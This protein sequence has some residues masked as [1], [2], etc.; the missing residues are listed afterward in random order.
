MGACCDP[1]VIHCYRWGYGSE[2]QHGGHSGRFCW[3][4]LPEGSPCRCASFSP[5][6]GLRALG[7]RSNPAGQAGRRRQRCAG[8][9]G[10]RG[11]QHGVREGGRAARCA[12]LPA[13][14]GGGGAAGRLWQFLEPLLLPA[15]A[16]RG[17]RGP[18][19]PPGTASR[20]EAAAPVARRPPRRIH[21]CSLRCRCTAGLPCCGYFP[22]VLHRLKRGRG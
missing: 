6:R 20:R 10:R 15:G 11:E 13:V 3:K 18:A 7:W 19:V 2:F 5:G 8:C 1:S 14:G 12:P 4:R 16:C 9:G 21:Q 22:F 17:R